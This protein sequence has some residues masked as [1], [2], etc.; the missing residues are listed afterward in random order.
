MA[1]T[2]PIRCDN[3]SYLVS[4][5]PIEIDINDADKRSLEYYETL[6]SKKLIDVH[7]EI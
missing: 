5:I 6:K 7:I 1:E 4:C 2:E 3:L